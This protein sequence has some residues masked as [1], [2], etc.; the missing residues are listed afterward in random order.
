[1]ETPARITDHPIL[2]SPTPRA[3]VTI[4]VDGQEVPA[5]EGE[6]IA[7]ALLAAGIRATRT[8]PETGSPR[9][10]FS[11]VG[12]SIEELGTVDGEANI[13]LFSTPVRAG[14]QI[15]T[16]QEHGSWDA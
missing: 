8:M 16:Q 14:M 6:P 4:L 2:G 11:G 12:R 7:M 13:P 10:M 5:L 15:M 9:G 3:E 1:M